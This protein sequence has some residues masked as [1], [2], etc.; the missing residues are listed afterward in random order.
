[1]RPNQVAPAAKSASRMAPTTIPPT[2]SSVKA[3]VR[4][5]GWREGGKRK[6]DRLDVDRLDVD[7]IEVDRQKD[8]KRNKP[9]L[10]LTDQGY[11]EEKQLIMSAVSSRIALDVAEESIM[12]YTS[13]S[14]P[15][16]ETI[17]GTMGWMIF[18]P[19]YAAR[20]QI[21]F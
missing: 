11:R 6:V 15:V 18:V 10:A 12:A 2:C 9:M 21:S 3:S 13:N 7:R 14:L 1:M 5:L 17:T 19:V 8:E 4:Y 16:A 20:S